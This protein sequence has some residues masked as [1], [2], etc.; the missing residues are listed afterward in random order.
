M[1]AVTPRPVIERKFVAFGDVVVAGGGDDR[2][3]ERVLAFGFD[4]C[5]G[6]QHPVVVELRR[7]RRRR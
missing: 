5:G 3:G 2:P 6:A 1:S 7:F 4:G